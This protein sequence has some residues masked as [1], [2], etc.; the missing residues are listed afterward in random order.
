MQ[1]TM[2]TDYAFR[3][4]IALAVVAPEMTTVGALGDR[5]RISA[6]HLSKVVQRLSDLGYVQT[7]RGKAGGVRLAVAAESVRLGDV[8]R[9]MEP[10]L[11]LAECLRGPP[12][13]CSIAP[14]CRLRG[15]L[16]KALEGFL[17]ALD[18]Y[19]LADLVANEPR[20][21]RLIALRAP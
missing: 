19:T 14:A 8:V 15:I 18:E 16:A 20:L 6:N 17:A 5:Y 4:L 7:L 10:E 2:H 3:T 11:G 1:L 12:N 13:R 21:E 9:G